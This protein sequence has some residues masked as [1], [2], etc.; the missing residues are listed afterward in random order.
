MHAVPLDIVLLKT[1]YREAFW[2]PVTLETKTL[3]FFETSGI[4]NSVTASNPGTPEPPNLVL[5]SSLGF[6]A[7]K[8]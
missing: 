8:V 1:R 7:S 2:N 4:P 3:R 5:L 6:H